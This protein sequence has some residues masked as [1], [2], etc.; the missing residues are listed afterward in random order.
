MARPPLSRW[1]LKAY[2]IGQSRVAVEGD[3]PGFIRRLLSRPELE[4][5]AS[6]GRLP[7]FLKHSFFLAAL[8]NASIRILA[9]LF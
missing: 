7:A 2:A 9:Y 3:S 8:R 6:A 4:C 1:S 5:A